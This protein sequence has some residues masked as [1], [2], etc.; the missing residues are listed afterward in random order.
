MD[1]KYTFDDKQKA[2]R[3]LIQTKLNQQCAIKKYQNIYL[4]TSSQI[5]WF[6]KQTTPKL[7]FCS[8]ICKKIFYSNLNFIYSSAPSK[9][10]CVT[11]ELL[12]KSSQKE[13]INFINQQKDYDNVMIY[14]NISKKPLDVYQ[15]KQSKITIKFIKNFNIVKEE[16][17][18]LTLIVMKI[19]PEDYK[20]LKFINPN[21][22][23]SL[24]SKKKLHTS[25]VNTLENLSNSLKKND[26]EILVCQHEKEN[27]EQG[28][29]K[30]NNFNKILDLFIL[31][32]LS[33]SCLY[34]LHKTDKLY[35][36]SLPNDYMT[37]VVCSYFCYKSFLYSNKKHIC[38]KTKNFNI[39]PP[40]IM[41]E[42]KKIIDIL[43]YHYIPDKSIYNTE[44]VRDDSSTDNVNEEENIQYFN[45]EAI[46]Y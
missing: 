19:K 40:L 10:T 34:C 20:Q 1:D 15:K 46:T 31:D 18:K 12:T 42:N 17:L 38:M 16:E 43:K 21:P 26:P 37:G 32:D 44:I 14:Y 35:F 9:V 24:S 6:C 36:I 7:N 2:L 5:C 23:T 39:L 22:E 29:A 8:I 30:I 13:Y 28:D 11:F 33:D 3:E 45:I 25:N 4:N 27:I 41:L